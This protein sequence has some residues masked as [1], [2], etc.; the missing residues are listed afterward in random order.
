MEPLFRAWGHSSFVEELSSRL[1]S[2][3]SRGVA[4]GMGG[5]AR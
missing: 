4:D 2:G 5:H 1:R 3:G